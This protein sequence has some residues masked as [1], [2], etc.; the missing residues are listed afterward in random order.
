MSLTSLSIQFF[1]YHKILKFY[2]IRIKLWLRVYVSLN[3]CFLRSYKRHFRKKRKRLL[4]KRV[5]DSRTRIFA[6]GD[7]SLHAAVAKYSHFLDPT[8]VDSPGVVSPGVVSPGVVSPRVPNSMSPMARDEHRCFLCK[9]QKQR[10]HS[11]HQRD[12]T[13]FPISVSFVR[14]QRDTNIRGNTMNLFFSVSWI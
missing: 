3:E 8:C 13:R 10:T 11:D 14:L 5:Y 1:S 12:V 7:E 4:R 2:C 6:V 9:Y